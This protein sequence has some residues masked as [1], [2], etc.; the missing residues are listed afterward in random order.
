MM[1]E[2]KLFDAMSDFDENYIQDAKN[3]RER[4][5]VR[6][7]L[8]AKSVAAAAIIVIL[9]GT[10]VYGAT[11]LVKQ[12]HMKGYTSVEDL[13]KDH[14]IKP[15]QSDIGYQDADFNEDAFKDLTP[16]AF[17]DI[18]TEADSDQE[19]TIEQGKATD[20]WN[21]KLIETDVD[22]EFQYFEAYDYDH[23]S[24][25]FED[26]DIKLD[27][28]YIEENYPRLAGEY[29]C[30]FYYADDSKKDCLQSRF[31]SG[32]R[33]ADENFVSVELASDQRSTN[34]DPYELYSGDVN[35]SYYTTK[36]GVEVYMTNTIGKSG[37]TYTTA[38][39]Y[40]EH[41][42]LTIGMYG[43]FASDEAEK[44]LDSL[45]IAEG[46]HIDTEPRVDEPDTEETQT[47]RWSVSEGTV[48]F[49]GKD[50]FEITDFDRYA[51]GYTDLCEVGEDQAYVAY[52]SKDGMI[53]VI[54]CTADGLGTKVASVAYNSYGGPNAAYL[55]F[56]DEKHGYLLYCSDPG[57]GMMTKVLWTTSDGGKNYTLVGDLTADIENYPSDI[58]FRDVDNG[59]ILVTNH[60][61]EAYAYLTKD[62][63]KTWTSYEVD[64][65]KNCNYINGVSIQPDGD[66]ASWN[67]TLEIVANAGS[68]TVTYHSD[69]D[70][71]SWT[72][73]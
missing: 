54:H 51:D 10:T 4:K 21:R 43:N 59:M 60:G 32:F 44:I 8:A 39:V 13:A 58:A 41:D 66:G 15:W 61:A 19:Y 65:Y 28:S 27:I 24:D 50:I 22:D 34:E 35:I 56:T 3:F 67:L 37:K 69:D 16:K 36:D 1:D 26:W 46:L 63:G 29:G 14:K 57:A 25:A 48:T 49:E 5:V 6:G 17:I 70:W 47:E 38:D 9:A 71:K 73:K 30:D 64:Q 20:K 31:F 53:S 52:Y 2:K 62:A 33:D 68:N 72:I 55:S 40:T 23:L 42:R 12:L 18:L 7:R 11:V 45:N